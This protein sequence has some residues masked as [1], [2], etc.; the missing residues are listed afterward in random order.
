[1]PRGLADDNALLASHLETQAAQRAAAMRLLHAH[2]TRNHWPDTDR[3]N[4]IAI[5]GLDTDQD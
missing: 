3:D 5:L 4:A 2:C 1:M